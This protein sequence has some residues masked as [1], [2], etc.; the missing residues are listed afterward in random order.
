MYQEETQP[1]EESKFKTIPDHVKD[2][3]NTQ[4]N[5]YR[6]TAIEVLAKTASSA[7]VG[8]FVALFGYL[9]LLFVSVA[10]AILLGG[11]FN[12]IF[13]GFLTVAGIYLVLA[14]LV[15]I[16]KRKLITTPLIN[17]IIKSLEKAENE[18]Q[19][20]RSAKPASRED[21]VEGNS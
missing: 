11:L 21:T 3:I 10:L 14:V 19:S 9:F 17:T 13:L 2:Y 6:L 12:N 1:S 8:V 15:I 7:A 5:Y 18:E 20:I 16:L 4:I